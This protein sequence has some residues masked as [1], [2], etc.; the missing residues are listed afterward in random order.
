MMKFGK[1][2]VGVSLVDVAVAIMDVIDEIMDDDIIESLVRIIEF[3]ILHRLDGIGNEFDS[4][5]VDVL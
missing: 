2:G 4:N 1:V 5:A 3:C